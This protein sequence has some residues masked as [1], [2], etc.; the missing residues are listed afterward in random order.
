MVVLYKEGQDGQ[1]RQ[2][3]IMMR[4]FVV[5]G[6]LTGNPYRFSNLVDGVQNMSSVTST[7]TWTNPEAEPDAKGD[8]TKVVKWEQTVGNLDDR[9]FT[10]P[11]DDARAHRGAI[12][13]D[14]ILMGYSWTPNWASAR[15]AHD[16]YDFHV[17]RSF[18][19]GQTWTTDPAGSGVTHYDTFKIYEEGGTEEDDEGREKY[20]D[21]TFYPAGAFEGALNI[22]KLPNNKESVIE[23]RIVGTPSTIKADGQPTGFPEDVQNQ[24]VVYLTFGTASNVPKPSG[25]SDDEAEELESAV[26]ADLFYTFTQDKGE[27][28]VETSWVVQGDPQGEDAPE[29]G[30]TV[31][32]WDWLAKDSAI[33]LE[34]GEAQIRMTPDGSRFYATWLEEN[35]EES[36]IWFRRIMPS[37]FECNVA[38]VV[39]GTTVDED[40]V[41]PL[42]GIIVRIYQQDIGLLEQ[43]VTNEDGAFTFDE[44][45]EESYVVTVEGNSAGFEEPVVNVTLSADSPKARVQFKK[46]GG[47]PGDLDGDGDV[48]SADYMV[49]RSTLG[50]CAGDAGFNSAADYDGDGC[51]TYADYRI[52]YGYFRS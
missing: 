3:D 41:T 27:T 12:R 38:N 15:N 48:D 40:E 52:W 50:K 42:A 13:G 33:E 25:S 11:Y 49:F 44:L 4:R 47:V 7:E 46:K 17:R 34:Q 21:E 45:S 20:T 39:A 22:S 19:G 18:D 10:N 1:G 31:T 26:P 29:T 32:G 5:P 35:E 9:S 8:Q 36:D 14:F 28:F 2:S 43:T 51:I 37:E 24:N 30:D 16:K 23:P 6:G